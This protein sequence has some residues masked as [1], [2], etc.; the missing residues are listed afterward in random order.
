M[1]ASNEV[2]LYLTIVIVRHTYLFCILFSV[3]FLCFHI[4]TESVG[5]WVCVCLCQ[6]YCCCDSI[7]IYT[8]HNA[9]STCCIHNFHVVSGF[10]NEY[11][12]T[13]PFHLRKF[14]RCTHRITLCCCCYCLSS[15]LETNC[16][17][18]CIPLKLQANTDQNQEWK[19]TTNETNLIT[20]VKLFI[21]CADFKSYYFLCYYSG[22]SENF[23]SSKIEWQKTAKNEKK[24]TFLAFFRILWQLTQRKQQNKLFFKWKRVTCAL[25][26]A[27]MRTH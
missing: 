19:K 22:P 20:T 3:E 10:V 18:A 25:V 24:A 4:A 23:N 26:F 14:S 12:W 17:T 27:M 21:P 13:P 15:H 2:L 11:E 1:L 7:R 6:P 16:H 9:Q 8:T 5:V